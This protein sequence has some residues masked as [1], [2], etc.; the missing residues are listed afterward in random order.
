MD[1]F[2]RRC[3][4]MSCTFLTVMSALKSIS[5]TPP[6]SFGAYTIGLGVCALYP[7]FCSNLGYSCRC[8]VSHC[9]ILKETATNPQVIL[10]KK[11]CL[12]DIHASFFR[13]G[14]E[15]R[16]LTYFFTFNWAILYSQWLSRDPGIYVPKLLNCF[17]SR[18]WLILC[19]IVGSSLP[20]SVTLFPFSVS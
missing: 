14:Q 6:D 18:L 3:L 2:A 16:N 20:S 5:P 9:S 17:G 19:S 8:S 1:V 12:Y 10:G 4:I 7:S 11:Y 13:S 15:L